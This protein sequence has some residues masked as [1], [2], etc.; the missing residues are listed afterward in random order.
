MDGSSTEYTYS[1]ALFLH[2]F[3]P[4]GLDD[5]TQALDEEDAAQNRQQQLFMDDNGTYADN[6]TNG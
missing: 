5:D 1:L 3:K 4:L 6:T 2:E